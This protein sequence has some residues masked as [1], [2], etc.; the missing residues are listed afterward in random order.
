MLGKFRA[1]IHTFNMKNKFN[2][3]CLPIFPSIQ[4][5]KGILRHIIKTIVM[6]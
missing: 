5:T 2:G 4:S 6:V 1:F 3:E